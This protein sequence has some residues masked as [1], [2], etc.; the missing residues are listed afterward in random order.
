MSCCKK[1]TVS[2][3][4]RYTATLWEKTGETAAS[5]LINRT[6]NVIGS[7]VSN[8]STGYVGTKNVPDIFRQGYNSSTRWIYNRKLHK[9]QKVTLNVGMPVGTIIRE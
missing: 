5:R 9:H 2:S 4:S 7:F 3:T 6:N 1:G 8:A